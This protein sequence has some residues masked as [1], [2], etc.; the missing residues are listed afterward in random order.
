MRADNFQIIALPKT[1]S[2]AF[3]ETRLFMFIT[4]GVTYCAMSFSGAVQ[5]SEAFYATPMPHMKNILFDAWLI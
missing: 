5:T 2:V 1:Q 4:Y 3:V